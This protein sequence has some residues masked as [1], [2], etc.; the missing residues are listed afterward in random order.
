MAKVNIICGEALGNWIY[1]KFIEAFNLYSKHTIMVNDS[2]NSD[3]TFYLPYYEMCV[4]SKRPCVVFMSHQEQNNKVLADKFVSSALTADFAVSMSKKYMELLKGCGVKN[5]IQIKPGVDSTKYIL[6]TK[7]SNEGKLIV[8]Y[9]GRKYSSTNRKNLKLL[10]KIMNLSF[11]DLR[12]TDG[13]ILE[14]DMPEF[15]DV[16]DLIAQPSL[17]EGGSMAIIEALSCGVPILC[18]NNV[19]W[20]DEFGIGVIKARFNDETNYLKQLYDFWR[21]KQYLYY[22]REDIMLSM[23]A[24]VLDISWYNF[25]KGF[26]KLFDSILGVDNG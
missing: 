17:I 21:D 15:Y 18:Y 10:D 3:I 6:R 5:I 13:K 14:Q 19:G 2:S 4:A 1:S 16:C 26:D 9:V 8:G 25:V 20:A 24:Q 7:K 22:E 11:V 23:R 12:I